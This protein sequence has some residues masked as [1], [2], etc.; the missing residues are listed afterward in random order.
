MSALGMTIVFISVQ[1]FKDARVKHTFRAFNYF[2]FFFSPSQ[3]CSFEL[4]PK[5]DETGKV[6]RRFFLVIAILGMMAYWLR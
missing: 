6:H 1:K 4:G 5:T 2:P 3:L